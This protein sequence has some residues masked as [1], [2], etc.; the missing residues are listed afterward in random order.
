MSERS[1]HHEAEGQAPSEQ[2]L[3]GLVHK[4]QK[5]LEAVE[6][7]LDMLLSQ[8]QAASQP[9][10][11]DGNREY[12]K[13]P[14]RPYGR[15]QRSFD[16][17]PRSF[18]R[19]PRSFDRE[20]RPFDRAPRSFDRSRPFERSEGEGRKFPPKKKFFAKHKKFR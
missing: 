10:E 11:Y 5:Q 14:Y 17:A 20:S 1:G 18:D 4:M 13:P 6:K 16:R 15:P 2:D 7:K 19:E 3:M 9:R 8:S 12:S